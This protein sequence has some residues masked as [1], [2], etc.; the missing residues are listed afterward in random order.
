MACK[1]QAPPAATR[2]IVVRR[3]GLEDA[4]VVH[5]LLFEFNGEALQPGALARRMLQV[6]GLETLFLAEQGGI[7]AGLLVLRIVPTISDAEDCAEI[8]ELYVRAPFQRQGIGTA[9]VCA[10][11]EHGRERGCV[12]LSLLVD[13]ANVEAQAF[14]QA[15][16][17]CR[18]SCRMR[19]RV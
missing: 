1:R 12:E 4:G 9:L 3:A 13:P 2:A 15:V 6:T 10:A 17:F 8:T 18:D 5:T 16:G 14:Y 11:V 19:R 7:P